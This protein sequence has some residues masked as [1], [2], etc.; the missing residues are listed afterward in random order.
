M[1]S[2]LKRYLP[3]RATTVDAVFAEI[4]ALRH[5]TDHINDVVEQINATVQQMNHELHHGGDSGLPLL[6]AVAERTR[7]DAATMVATTHAMDR[8]LGTAVKR[9][10][11]AA[12]RFD[13]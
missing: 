10:E 4:V 13:R 7:T 2:K 5:V 11:E 8:S 1:K 6:V 3:A 12:E 9:L